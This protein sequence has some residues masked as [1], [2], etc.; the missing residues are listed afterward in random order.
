MWRIG[1]L[2]VITAATGASAVST[3]GQSVEVFL[4]LNKD[5]HVRCIRGSLDRRIANAVQDKIA[6]TL[7][8]RTRAPCPIGCFFRRAWTVIPIRWTTTVPLG[9]RYFVMPARSGPK[10]KGD[11]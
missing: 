11:T 1:G 6:M 10:G 7:E 5:F 4:Q 3:R 2:R 9:C 8:E